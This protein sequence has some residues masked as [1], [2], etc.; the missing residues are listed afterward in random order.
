MYFYFYTSSNTSILV[1][2]ISIEKHA[3]NTEEMIEGRTSQK[4]KLL[5]IDDI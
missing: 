3:S 2:L 4:R 1:D 5:M